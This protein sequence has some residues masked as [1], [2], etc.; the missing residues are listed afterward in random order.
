MAKQAIKRFNAVEY[1]VQK[2]VE[3]EYAIIPVQLKNAEEFFTP[4]DPTQTTLNP[5]ISSYIDRCVY[6]IPVRFKIKLNIISELTISEEMQI[7]MQNAVKNHYGLIVYDKNLDLRINTYKTLWLLFCGIFF[8]ALVYAAS[9]NIKLPG[10]F[11]SGQN[12]L[13][14]ILLVTGWFF[15][16]E[17]VEN[18]VSNRRKLSIDKLNN[19]QMLNSEFLFETKKVYDEIIRIENLD[20]SEESREAFEEDIARMKEELKAEVTNFE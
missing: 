2:Y 13:K 14:E 19:K 4:Q 11:D 10:I 16:W 12:I 5:V 20:D 7:K 6:N 17:A 3:G 8:L 1:L 9:L 15:V 18:F